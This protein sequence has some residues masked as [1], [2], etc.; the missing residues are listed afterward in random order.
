[1]K[2]PLSP[3][4]PT[5]RPRPRFLPR[6]LALTTAL[7][8][9]PA[10]TMPRAGVAARQSGGDGV[11]PLAVGGPPPPLYVIFPLNSGIGAFAD[12]VNDAQRVV[13]S[14]HDSLG[15]P[16]HAAVWAGF[17]PLDLG[18]LGGPSSFASAINASDQIAGS[19]QT[20]N[21]D[22][23]AFLWTPADG[24]MH[25]L[26]IAGRIS[27]ANAINKAGDVAGQAQFPTR[28]GPVLR[29]ALWHHNRLRNLGTLGSDASIATGINDRGQVAGTS[30]TAQGE[31]HAF[32]WSNGKLRDLGTLGGTLTE[33]QGINGRGDVVGISSTGQR[34]ANGLDIEHAFLWHNGTMLDLGTLGGRDSTAFAI[35]DAGL[36][37][38][39]SQD[40]SDKPIAFLSVGGAM[41]DLNALVPT[42]PGY[43]LTRATGISKS[44]QI[45]AVGFD[46]A[47][48]N[49]QRAFLLIRCADDVTGQVQVTLDP[50][51]PDFLPGHWSQTV[52]LR[53]VS[54]HD[55]A[56]PISFVADHL[57]PPGVQMDHVDVTGGLPPLGSPYVNF[58][59]PLKRNRTKTLTLGFF[60]FTNQPITYTPRLLA[61]PD[62]R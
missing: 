13:G 48:P 58:T 44:G 49:P 23:H 51:Q 29:A 2:R 57:Q 33:A 27:Q 24:V 10:M 4:W 5:A 28:N 30:E 7:A 19:A 31:T 16:F 12:G 14:T 18:T 1:M 43:H 54:G 55:I 40:S 53:N 46:P 59:G 3:H 56:G 50:I 32:R 52:H 36:I 42:N 39:S 45:S 41:F 17:T 37:V 21:N 26:G 6:L 62:R 38:G 11:T 60:I 35:N 8:A 15:T 34:D 20:A 22:T 9:L 47:D 61:G 25:D